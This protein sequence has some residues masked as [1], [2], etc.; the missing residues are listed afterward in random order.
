MIPQACLFFLMGNTLAE[1][2]GP[3]ALLRKQQSRLFCACASALL[4]QG[5][6]WQH[7]RAFFWT[8]TFVGMTPLGV[9]S[10]RAASGIDRLKCSLYGITPWRPLQEGTR[11]GAEGD[12]H[13]LGE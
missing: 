10:R 6:R 3:V 2:S 9:P 13:G 7:G 4:E 11:A 5:G 8:A 12:P 1:C